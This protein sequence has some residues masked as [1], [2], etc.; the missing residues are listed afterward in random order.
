[1]ADREEPACPCVAGIALD[2]LLALP[3][4][5]WLIASVTEA[6]SVCLINGAKSCS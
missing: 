4:S 1:M 6:G 5:L 3:R 2:C